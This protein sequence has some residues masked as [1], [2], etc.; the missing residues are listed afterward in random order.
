MQAYR[1]PVYDKYI[2]CY[3]DED[4][5]FV[6]L[7]S[8]QDNKFKPSFTAK[9]CEFSLTHKTYNPMVELPPDETVHGIIVKVIKHSNAAK[10]SVRED[11]YLP[12]GFRLI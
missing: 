3:K 10:L 2:S 8:V 11:N 6:I 7:H 9:G 4:D 12:M 1:N 5:T